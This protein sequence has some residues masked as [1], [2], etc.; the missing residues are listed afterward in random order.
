MISEDDAAC[1]FCFEGSELN[2]PLVNPCKC[3]G[4]M[5]Y[6]HLQCI[7]KWRKH[8]TNL[9]WVRR[10][11]LCLEDYEIVLLCLK[12]DAPHQVPFL[13]LLTK[14]HFVVSCMLYYF[15]L[16]FLTNT[17]LTHLETYYQ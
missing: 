10:C 8:T 1:R 17:K 7:K 9:E 5:K 14:R 16:T 13:H 3:I 15:H 4:S 11:Q 2:N 12:E 6:V